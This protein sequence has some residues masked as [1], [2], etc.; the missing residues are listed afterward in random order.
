MRRTLGLMLALT[1]FVG[2][3][4]GGSAT[5]TAP[6]SGGSG[7]TGSGA[8]G[9]GA[10]TTSTAKTLRIAVIPKGTSHV[11]WKSVHAGAEQAAK[12]LGNVEIQW[13]GPLEEDQTDSQIDVVQDFTT[14]KVDGICVAPN[15][16][17]ALVAAVTE[18]VEA[19]I[20][21]VVFDSALQDE[22]KIVSYVATF[23][24]TGVLVWAMFRRARTL[25]QRLPPEDRPWT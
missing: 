11:F 7:A 19:G 5:K 24:G 15:D 10:T 17:Q 13:K 1:L 21:V 4:G 18:A 12:E 6:K 3:D 2:C 25:A 9:V 20:P 16:K 14:K 8:S 22:S 23:G